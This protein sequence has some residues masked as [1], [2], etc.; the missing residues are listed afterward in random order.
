MKKLDYIWGQYTRYRDH[1]ETKKTL[2]SNYGSVRRF[3]GSKKAVLIFS[4]KNKTE[5]IIMPDNFYRYFRPRECKSLVSDYELSFI[6]NYARIYYTGAGKIIILG[7]WFGGDSISFARGLAE[8]SHACTRPV[9][10]AYDIFIYL[11][12]MNQFCRDNNLPSYHH[13]ESFFDDVRKMLKPYEDYVRL[14]EQNLELPV[15]FPDPVEMLFIDVWKFWNIA[16]NTI[17]CFFPQLFINSYVVQQ[18]FAHF[19][20]Y[21]SSVHL[22]MWYYR[23]HFEYIGH[24]FDSGSVIFRLTSLIP[25]DDI[26]EFT[27]D[28][29]SIGMIHEAYD[30]AKDCV[31]DQYKDW[32]LYAKLSHMIVCGLD[33]PVY[34]ELQQWEKEGRYIDPVFMPEYDGAIK[35]RIHGDPIPEDIDRLVHALIRDKE[36]S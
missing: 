14:H 25:A 9:V 20:S 22:I 21:T 15:S 35:R 29:F 6:E 33:R 13:G 2:R 27:P 11:E 10:E 1:M 34:Q 5:K 26:P 16:D 19:S 31:S 28:F 32:I 17:R 18:D 12:W 23:D 7:C 4:S 36:T 30:W 24:V 8:N 3:P